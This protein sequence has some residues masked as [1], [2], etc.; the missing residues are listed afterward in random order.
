MSDPKQKSTRLDN[1]SEIVS[2]D[3]L[4]SADSDETSTDE[5]ISN[6]TTDAELGSSSIDHESHE[7]PFLSRGK[8]PALIAAFLL[9]LAIG[10]FFYQSIEAAYSLMYVAVEHSMHHASDKYYRWSRLVVL[11]HSALAHKQYALA[12]ILLSAATNEAAH[13]SAPN[14][15]LHDTLVDLGRAWLEE[16]D[17]RQ[18]ATCFRQSAKLVEQLSGPR[19]GELVP[20]LCSMSDALIRDHE[21]NEAQEVIN[22]ARLVANA[23]GF[24]QGN[25]DDTLVRLYAATGDKQ[26]ENQYK[27]AAFD[28]ALAH[29]ARE[30]R[31]A[32]DMHIRTDTPYYRAETKAGGSGDP[33]GSCLADQA[34][35]WQIRGD[36]AKADQL[37]RQEIEIRKSTL[38][39][40]DPVT[41]EAMNRYAG[42]LR[43][44]ERVK[45]AEQIENQVDSI[46]A[47]ARS[48]PVNYHDTQNWYRDGEPLAGKLTASWMMQYASALR[49]CGLAA[50]ARRFDEECQRLQHKYD[51]G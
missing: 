17:A 4:P 8:K 42:F 41:A 18:A 40:R 2:S 11:G 22:Q 10:T 46:F 37:Y 15:R 44:T 26:R 48:K 21:F 50:E 47:E 12:R 5:R 7:A 45:Q 43:A 34:Y 39:E 9:L 31:F 16:G 51:A 6:D 33:D 24:Y 3:T 27:L 32:R 19:S 36:Y 23:S 30:A 29:A 25:V 20:D 38:G 14:V 49:A 28:S 13:F 35:S 1:N